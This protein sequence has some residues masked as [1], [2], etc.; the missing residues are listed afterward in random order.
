[1][2]ESIN[3]CTVQWRCKYVNALPLNCDPSTD[4]KLECICRKKGMSTNIFPKKF[5]HLHIHHSFLWTLCSSFLNRPSATT[6]TQFCSHD[7]AL[8]AT[9]VNRLYMFSKFFPLF[10][11]DAKGAFCANSVT[12]AGHYLPISRWANNTRCRNCTSLSWRTG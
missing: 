12:T 5:F 8:G 3:T 1:M 6:G 11:D 9:A 10:S 4:I 2:S 7:R